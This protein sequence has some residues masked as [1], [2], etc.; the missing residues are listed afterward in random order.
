M[1]P[2]ASVLPDPEPRST[3]SLPSYPILSHLQLLPVNTDTAVTTTIMATPNPLQNTHSSSPPA[4]SVTTIHVAG[5][6]TDIYGLEELS[7]SCKSISCLWLLHPRLQQR[8]IMSSVASSCINDWKQRTSSDSTGLIAVAFDQ[9]NHG[10]RCVKEL[11]NEA[12]RGGN[13]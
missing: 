13:V 12:W 6:L 7:P 9:R 2:L 5:I 10:S 8:A 1:P 4:I 3:S 11:A